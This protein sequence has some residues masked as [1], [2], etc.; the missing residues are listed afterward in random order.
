[1]PGR[2]P[3]TGR[4]RS[5]QLA[6]SATESENNKSS[7]AAN[8]KL[9]KGDTLAEPVPPNIGRS[10]LRLQHWAPISTIKSIRSSQAV[11]GYISREKRRD[12]NCG[13]RSFSGQQG[14]V[15]T[16]GIKQTLSL[17]KRDLNI[18]L[19]IMTDMSGVDH[20]GALW[21][22]AF[23]ADKQFPGVAIF[24]I[25]A[26]ARRPGESTSSSDSPPAARDRIRPGFVPRRAGGFPDR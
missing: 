1:M 23:V 15:L 5:T 6:E 18:P 8:S 17:G 13:R 9:T 21:R 4:R 2:I 3:S 20:Q 11:N 19:R 14:I 7:D 25:H 10:V 16:S 24:A 26:F 12:S 22:F